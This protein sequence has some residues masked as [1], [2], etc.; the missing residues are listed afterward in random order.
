MA[1]GTSPLRYPGGKTCFYN[2]VAA[3]L[4]QNGLERGHYAEPFAGGFGL[5][6]TLLYGGHVADVHIDD[7]DESI[8]SFWHSLLNRTARFVD[9]VVNTPVTIDEWRRQREVFKRGNSS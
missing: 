4:R 9:K 8:W 1:S 6:L 3:M 2:L 5:G 7:I